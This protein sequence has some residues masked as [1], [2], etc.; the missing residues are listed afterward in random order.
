MKR[1]ALVLLIWGIWGSLACAKKERLK[2]IYAERGS[3][4]CTLNACLSEYYAQKLYKLPCCID[5]YVCITC[6]NG[7]GRSLIENIEN[8]DLGEAI[9]RAECKKDI[10]KALKVPA[11]YARRRIL[12][13]VI[14][15]PFCRSYVFTSPVK[16]PGTEDHWLKQVVWKKKKEV[17]PGG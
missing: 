3:A 11:E 10:V 17:I 2:R 9:G 7:L 8:H 6:L 5:T 15:C 13:F 14:K 16:I 4:A 1:L 12:N